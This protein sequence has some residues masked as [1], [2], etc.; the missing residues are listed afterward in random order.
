MPDYAPLL[1]LCPVAS[2]MLEACNYAFQNASII[3]WGQLDRQASPNQP[4][5]AESERAGSELT[6]DIDVYL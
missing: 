4:S 6:V 2:I 1:R 5:A 3:G